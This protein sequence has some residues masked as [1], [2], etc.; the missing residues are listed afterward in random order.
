MGRIKVLLRALKLTKNRGTAAYLR[1]NLANLLP[2]VKDV[3]LLIDELAVDGDTTFRDAGGELCDLLL[4]ERLQ[5][6]EATR[7]W[8]LELIVRGHV[9]LTSAQIRSLDS[10]PGV[11]DARQLCLIRGNMGDVNYFRHKKARVDELPLWTQAAFIFAAK[12]LP[13]DEYDHWL[14]SIKSRVR[15]P[16]GAQ[17]IEW[18]RPT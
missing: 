15:F 14:R 10:L 3:V 13:N 17:F 18:C 16:L 8:L 5:P 2:F 6:L 9:S 1:T 7:A 11:L 12:C 4:S